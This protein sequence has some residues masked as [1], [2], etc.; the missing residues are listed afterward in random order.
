MGSFQQERRSLGRGL[1]DISKTFLSSDDQTKDENMYHGFSSFAIRE[2]F[3]SSCIHML[4]SPSGHLMCK[5]FTLENKKYGVKYLESIT[6]SHAR[7]CEY[8]EAHIPRK[9]K[10]EL[11]NE[12]ADGMQTGPQY[13]VEETVTVKKKIEYQDIG[14]VQ[15]KMRT[16]LSNHIQ[17]GYS[18]KQVLLRKTEETSNSGKREVRNEEVLISAKTPEPK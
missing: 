3:C 18:I 1:A 16:A 6:P 8:F 4:E 13:E 2:A 14:N 5:V 7:Y 15:Q 12:T 10:P 9:E 17:E 11:K